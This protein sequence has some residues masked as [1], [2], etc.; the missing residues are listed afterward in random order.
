MSVMRCLFEN[1]FIN[2]KLSR[3][4]FFRGRVFLEIFLSSFD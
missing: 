2:V 1:F 4:W 3:F